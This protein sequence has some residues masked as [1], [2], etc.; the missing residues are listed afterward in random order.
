MCNA[1]LSKQLYLHFL[2]AVTRLDSRLPNGSQEYFTLAGA[3]L[4]E[5]SK[6]LAIPVRKAVL[7]LSYFQTLV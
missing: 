7:E 1:R 4:A 5:K 3:V 2:N 6:S